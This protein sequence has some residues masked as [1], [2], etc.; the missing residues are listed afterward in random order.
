V[1]LVTRP[2]F[3]EPFFARISAV[4]LDRVQFDAATHNPYAALGTGYSVG[5]RPDPRVADLIDA[6]LGEARTVL[7]VGAGTGSYEP[8]DRLVAAV[9]PSMAMIGQ[10]SVAA[11]PVVRGAAERLP[12]ADQ[13]FDVALAILTVHD[14]TDASAG[15]AGS[16][17]AGERRGTADRGGASSR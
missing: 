11:A 17:R 16:C 10:R 12:F 9:E 7:N 2:Y 5:R 4:S 15:L 8:R 3:V 1:T 13:A 6:A 14:W